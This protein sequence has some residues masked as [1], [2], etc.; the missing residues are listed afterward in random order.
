MSSPYSDAYMAEAFEVKILLKLNAG[1]NG[2]RVAGS[3]RNLGV[4]MYGVDSFDEQ[5][6]SSSGEPVCV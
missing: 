2:T 6:V 4:E 3:I 5:W 1:A